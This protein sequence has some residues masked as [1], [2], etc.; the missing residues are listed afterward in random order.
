MTRVFLP[1]RRQLLF[2]FD[3]KEPYADLQLSGKTALRWM[4]C[5]ISAINVHISGETHLKLTLDS[6]QKLDNRRKSLEGA[7]DVAMLDQIERIGR[8]R[9]EKCVYISKK[10][11]EKAL[12]KLR[13]KKASPEPGR[14][15]EISLQ[16]DAVAAGA[17]AGGGSPASAPDMVREWMRAVV[18]IG[19]VLPTAALPLHLRSKEGSVVIGDNCFYPIGSGFLLEGAEGLVFTCEHVR[20]LCQRTLARIP[21]GFLAVCPTVGWEAEWT[22]ARVGLVLAHTKQY[23]AT[24]LDST[25]PYDPC[26]PT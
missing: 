9:G 22:K 26:D 17:A 3:K 10:D 19:L 2:D 21:G 16:D 23:A 8:R 6:D 15:K 14:L 24:C 25:S 7:V 13:D 20:A 11:A 4:L 18:R 5:D 1:L 12:G